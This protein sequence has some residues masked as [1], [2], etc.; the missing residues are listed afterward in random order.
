MDRIR[1]GGK[2]QADLDAERAEE[3]RLRIND[4]ARAYLRETD[5]YF[6]RQAETGA[7][8]PDE[9]RDERQAARARVEEHNNDRRTTG[10]TR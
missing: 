2:T 7:V 10:Q 5:W 4:E 1:V 8:M 3:E 9:I 6:I